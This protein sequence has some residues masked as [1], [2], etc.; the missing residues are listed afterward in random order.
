MLNMN[1]YKKTKVQL[2]NGLTNLR[3]NTNVLSD[4]DR[5]DLHHNHPEDEALKRVHELE[6]ETAELEAQIE[7]LHQTLEELEFLRN[8]YVE[9][10]DF[11][12]IGYFTFDASGLIREAN[13]AGAQLLGTDRRLLANKPFHHFI[14]DKEG[15]NAFTNH[16]VRVLRKSDIQRCEISLKAQNGM[17]IHCLLQSRTVGTSG[18]GECILSTV[19]DI[20]GGKHLETDSQDT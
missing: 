1:D 18:K 14:Y 4:L 2:I 17:V 3:R 7:E 13:L 5:A 9:L 6:V 10:Y 12:P 15:K 16:L 20:N 11:A 8:K 19:I